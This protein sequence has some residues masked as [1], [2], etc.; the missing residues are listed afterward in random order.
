MRVGYNF[1]DIAAVYGRIGA[2]I[3]KKHILSVIRGKMPYYNQTFTKLAPAFG[4]G[5]MIKNFTNI[6]TGV[7]YRF[8]GQPKHTFTIKIQTDNFNDKW[9]QPVHAVL[10]KVSYHF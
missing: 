7:E 5:F 6:S 8:T 10:A 1:A 9:K 2:H 4:A 3:Y